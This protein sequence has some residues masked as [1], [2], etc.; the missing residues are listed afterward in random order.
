[1]LIMSSA[2]LRVSTCAAFESYIF[3]DNE[4]GE[5]AMAEVA[6]I[7]NFWE[8]METRFLPQYYSTVTFDGEDHPE[9]QNDIFAY[10]RKVGGIRIGQVRLKKKPCVFDNSNFELGNSSFFLLW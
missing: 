4:F 8:Y 2:K 3:E 5:Q 7:G 1:M 6:S 10:N 9:L